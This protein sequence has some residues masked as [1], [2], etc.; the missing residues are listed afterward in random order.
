MR[1]LFILSLALVLVAP[2]LAAPFTVLVYNVEN[3]TA[4]DGHTLSEDYGPARYSRDHLL[5]KMNNIAR[6]VAQF[7]EGRGPDIILFQEI[8]RDFQKDQ[9]LFDHAGMLRHY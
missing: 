6:V 3:L 7:D 8:E 2:A 5:T 9:Y 4:A 1:S